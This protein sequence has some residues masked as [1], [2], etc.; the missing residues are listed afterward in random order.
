M[1]SHNKLRALPLYIS[2]AFILPGF[3]SHEASAESNN[4]RFGKAKNTRLS[5]VIDQVRVANR[6]DV[7]FL[8]RQLKKRLIELAGRPHSYLPLTAFA[9]APD[10]SRLFQYYLLDT[11]NFQP[12]VF[13]SAIPGINDTAIPTGA[14][15]ANGG[16]PT[17]A[18]VRMVIEPKPGL[19]TDPNDPGAFIDMFTDI[20]GLFVINNEADGTRAG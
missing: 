1:R 17:I 18:A 20:S 9:E 7:R 2:M 5:S 19:P 14:N 8:P 13:T 4:P 10:P 6:G 11:N 15:F 16:L 12:N 3:A